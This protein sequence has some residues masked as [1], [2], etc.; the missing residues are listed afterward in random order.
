MGDVVDL[1]AA[2]RRKAGEPDPA[3]VAD[4]TAE[5]RQRVDAG[6]RVL[7]ERPRRRTGRYR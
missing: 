1:D 3:A 5:A 6:R 2:R 4:L 7:D